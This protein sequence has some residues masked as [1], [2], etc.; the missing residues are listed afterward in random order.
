MDPKIF[1]NQYLQKESLEHFKIYRG[2]SV[3]VYLNF[4]KD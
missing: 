3:Q 4:K 2:N 1:Y